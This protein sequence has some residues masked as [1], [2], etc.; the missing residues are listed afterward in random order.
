MLY[1]AIVRYTESIAV[2]GVG[3]SAFIVYVAFAPDSQPSFLAALLVLAALQVIT[4]Y[5]IGDMKALGLIF[6]LPIFATFVPA[7]QGCPR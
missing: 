6:F 2:Y 3:V 1:I 4:G 7:P 5:V